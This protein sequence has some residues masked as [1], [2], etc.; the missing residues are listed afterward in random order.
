MPRMRRN[1]NLKLHCRTRFSHRTPKLWSTV[2]EKMHA[3]AEKCHFDSELFSL[4]ASLDTRA[5]A[6]KVNRKT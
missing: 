6:A 1:I 2:H 5:K 4:S 3:D